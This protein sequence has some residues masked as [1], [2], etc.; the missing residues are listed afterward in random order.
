MSECEGLIWVLQILREQG[1]CWTCI[2]DVSGVGG[3]WV[4]VWNMVWKGGVVLCMCE[5]GFF[6]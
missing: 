6:M 3:D 1:E 5:S 2:R 4:G